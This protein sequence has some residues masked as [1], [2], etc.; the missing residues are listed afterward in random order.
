MDGKLLKQFKGRKSFGEVVESELYFEV[1]LEDDVLE[2]E[3]IGHIF[4]LAYSQQIP[5]KP[6]LGKKLV[7]HRSYLGKSKVFEVV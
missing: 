6:T 5:F 4:Q 7:Y 3:L 1:G 2:L